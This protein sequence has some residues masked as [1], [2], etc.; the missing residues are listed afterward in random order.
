MESNKFGLLG[1][2]SSVPNFIVIG[3]P[4]DCTH[5]YC[6]VQRRRNIHRKSNE[7]HELVSQELLGQ[8]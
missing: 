7:F 8:I 4:E 1:N 6:L 3:V 5:I 2:T